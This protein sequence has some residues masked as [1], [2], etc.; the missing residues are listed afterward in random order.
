[1]Q[2]ACYA[3]RT[4]AQ[5]ITFLLTAVPPKLR[6][7]L[8]ELLI[9]AMISRNGHITDALLA[10][11][12][13]RFWG[14]YHKIIEKG[15]F[16]WMKLARR[17]LQL[18]IH[19]FGVEAI[20]LAIDDFITFRSSKKA[21]SCAIHH[22]HAHRSNRPK[23]V[24]GQLRVGLAAIVS[25]NNQHGALPILMRLIRTSGN[26]SKI[27][28][29]KLLM[30]IVLRWFPELVHVRVLLDAWFM[31]STFILPMVEKGITIIGQVRKD[32]A[33][34][35]VPIKQPGKGRP[36]KY[37]D[38][39]TWKRIQE[40][41]TSYYTTITAY[42]KELLFQYYSGVAKAKFLKGRLVRFVWCR[43]QKDTKQW[44]NWHL[45]IT[46]DYSINPSTVIRLFT[47][48]WWVEP[49]FNELKNLFGMCNAWQ[50]AK[51]SLARWTM[52]LSL[53]Y[54]LP[55]LLALWLGPEQGAKFFSIPWRRNKPVTAGWIAIG[56]S[57][58]FQGFPVRRLWD[59]K[60]QKMVLPKEITDPNLERAA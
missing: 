32:T 44:T 27:R 19:L 34:Y 13:H 15:R 8:L 46:T 17:W 57:Y 10:I 49:M 12:I 55:K 21:P 36:R 31:K 4:L 52:I 5:W 40:D 2:V 45:I 41:Y 9:G 23:F 50:Q 26:H 28:T 38:R 6:P 14:T 42:G 35:D 20:N 3:L 25:K 53:A 30:N 60:S 16:E 11:R 39:I 24:R 43:F 37:G 33:F 18:L 48:R 54:S 51:Q 47:L 56:L 29:A 1:M 58:Y 59:R 7:T 22:D